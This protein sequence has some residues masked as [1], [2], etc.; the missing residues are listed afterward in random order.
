MAVSFQR[1]SL[2]DVREQLEPMIAT[3]YA[4][5]A[6]FADEIP[7]EPNWA[8][9]KAVERAGLLRIYTARKLRLVGYSVCYITRSMMR[10]VEEANEIAL[11]LQPALRGTTVGVRLM[12]F[13]EDQLRAEGVALLARCSKVRADVNIGLMLERMG[14]TPVDTI[15]F[16]K[17]K[18]DGHG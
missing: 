10:A 5:T 8:G 17:L 13:V 16:R 3:H 1:E 7:I 4:E 12:R 14:Y 18:D 6:V 9:Y 2:A 11:Y 15:Y